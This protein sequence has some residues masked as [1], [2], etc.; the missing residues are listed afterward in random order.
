[1]NLNFVCKISLIWMI[2][3]VPRGNPVAAGQISAQN[4]IQDILSAK[5]PSPLNGFVKELQGNTIDYHSAIASAR[6]ALLVRTTDGKQS[7]QWQTENIP[8]GRKKKFITFAWL[9]A[10]SGSKG[11]HKFEMSVNGEPWCNFNSAADSAAKSW[12]VSAADGGSLTFIATEAD[13]F[14]DLFGYMFMEVP[15]ASFKK[16]EALTIR[17]SGA[18]EGSSAWY[19]TFRYPMETKIGIHV[20]PALVYDL[21]TL[22]HIVN[23]SID[24]FSVSREVSVYIDPLNVKRLKLGWG[25]N[26]VLIP[27]KAVPSEKQVELTVEAHGKI[28]RREKILLQ[29]VRRRELYLLPH[30]HTDIGYSSYQTDVQ[31][32]H[33]RYIG[34]AIE[35]SKRSEAYPIGARFKWNIEVLWEL[36]SYLEKTDEA[37]RRKVV[38]A[39]KRGWIGVNGLYANMLTGLCRPEELMRMTAYGRRLSR[40]FGI[41]INS[42][43]ITDIPSYTSSTVTALAKSGIRYFSSGP[44]Y[45]PG[46]PDGGDRI[47]GSLKAWGDKPF[48]WES[49]SG[50]SRVLFWMAGKGY[51][52]FHGWIMG[53]LSHVNPEPIFGYIEKLDS[54]HYPYDMVQLRYTIDG[55]NG[56]P[57]PDLPDFVMEWNKK[58]YSPRFVIS[59]TAEM[60][61]EFE[62]RYGKDL[63]VVRGDLTPYWEDGAAS[64]ARELA[65]NR[66]S[67]ELLVQAEALQSMVNPALYKPDDFYC[68]WR[69]VLLFDEHTW[70]AWN[71]ISEPDSPSVKA[72]WD[73]KRAFALDG[74]SEAKNLLEH[75]AAPR[76]ASEPLAAVDIVNTNSWPRTDVVVLPKGMKTAGARVRDESGTPVP[77]QILSTGELAIFVSDVPPMCAKRLF[78]YSGDPYG[79]EAG[80]NASGFKLT[81]E[82]LSL[83]VNPRTGAVSRL[84]SRKLGRNVVDTSIGTGLNEYL[85]VPGR[86]PKA[87]LKDSGVKISVKEKGP[88]V[89]S[90]LIES[91][92]EGCYTLKREVRITAGL[93]GGER[94]DITDSLDKKKVRQKESVHFGF[95][96]NIPQGVLRLDEGWEA[97][98]P[99]SGQMAGACKDFFTVQRWADVSNDRYGVTWA[100]VDAPLLEVGELTDESQSQGARSWRDKINPS[101]N[102]YS[103][104]MNNYWHTNY[105]ADQEGGAVFH[106]SLIPHDAFK[107]ADAVRFGIERSQALLVTP[108]GII[109]GVA[110]PLFTLEGQ[111]VIA[112]S[113]KP[114]DDSKGWIVR[115]FN[116]GDKPADALL[117]WNDKDRVRVISSN[118]FEEGKDEVKFPLKIMPGGIATFRVEPG[119]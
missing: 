3:L 39:I 26:S 113:V 107:K 18:N 5:S 84:V 57:D 68:A 29:P 21:D 36:E 65:V 106:Y 37:G 110:V 53:R 66:N 77:S 80:V 117:R 20:P 111:D 28:E 99:E 51:S 40:E 54:E 79:A 17:V 45:V 15:V 105:K 87:V 22:C 31:R 72:Q 83:E 88:L 16:G 119:E 38:D 48:Y 1:M 24:N 108:A 86:D 44:N 19:M 85:Y 42:A 94:V 46:L 52:W 55:D 41:N 90:L 78:F 59:T 70:G 112:T 6:S 96:F 104:V 60:F 114:A 23:V 73:Y 76:T 71:S 95:P 11:V 63:P 4:R 103:Y 92:P 43:M 101:Q 75:V 100:T 58:Y 9:A 62:R 33:I 10:I 47:G 32:D 102:F 81:G 35:I 2:F 89:A 69:K 14:Q 91:A 49:Q 93:A 74:Q 115:L 25:A 56:P 61:E 116:A 98:S 64:T 34:E 8:A 12:T 27:V 50:E 109:M 13:R 7:I 30:S 118:L 82:D 97:V 67:A